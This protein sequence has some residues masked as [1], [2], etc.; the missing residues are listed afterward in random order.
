MGTEANDEVVLRTTQTRLIGLELKLRELVDLSKGDAEA[1]HGDA[2]DL[3]VELLRH[4]GL[5]QIADAYQA[6]HKWYA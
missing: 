2:D 5:N 1:A 3:L 4:L 6:I